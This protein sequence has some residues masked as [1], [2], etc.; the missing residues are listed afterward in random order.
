ML[1]ITNFLNKHNLLVKYFNAQKVSNIINSLT[2]FNK[3]ITLLD[4]HSIQYQRM[5]HE[6][7]PT[8]EDSAKVRGTSM[9]EG[10]KSIIVKGKK[11]GKNYQFNLPSHLKLDMKA[12]AHIVGE[13]CEF[14][15]P[16]VILERFDLQIGGIPPFGNLLKLTNYVEKRVL[17]SERAAFNC[18][19]RTESLIVRSA[20]LIKV[21]DPVIESFAKEGLPK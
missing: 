15:K 3:I 8:S 4:Q 20:D 9:Q 17:S 11:T 7:T 14:E 10:V 19:L 13:K 6:E 1:A 16:E 12:A 21:T 18:G 5:T 2:L